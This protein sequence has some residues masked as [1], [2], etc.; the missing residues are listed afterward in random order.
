MVPLQLTEME[1]LEIIM[2]TRNSSQLINAVTGHA[3]FKNTNPE[4]K[5]HNPFF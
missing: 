5:Y 4:Q 1:K 2:E 3:F